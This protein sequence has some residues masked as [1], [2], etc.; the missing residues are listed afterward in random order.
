MHPLEPSVFDATGLVLRTWFCSSAD[1]PFEELLPARSLCSTPFAMNASRLDGLPAAFFRNA[2]SLTNGTLSVDLLPASV[3]RFGAAV[4]ADEVAAPSFSNTF[5]QVGGNAGASGVLGTT[6]DASLVL[7]AGGAETVFVCPDGRVGIGTNA[8]GDGFH[9][10]PPA[11]F[12]QGIVFVK[13]L[14][15]LSM[16]PYTNMP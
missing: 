10:L 11:R 1:G 14:G 5:W 16:G 13:P 6:T 2:D 7:C 12:E 3:S 4:E 8:P 9:V 15:D